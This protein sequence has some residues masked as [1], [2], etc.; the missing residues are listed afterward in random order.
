MHRTARLVVVG[1]AMVM[2]IVTAGEI[3]PMNIGLELEMNSEFNTILPRA[4]ATNF[5]TFTG[6]LGGSPPEPITA[7]SNDAT[8][9]FTCSGETFTKLSDAVNRSCN[10]QK[11]TCSQAANSAGGGGGGGDKNSNGLTVGQCD[12]QLKA[13]TAAT[14]GLVGLKL[15]TVADGAENLVFC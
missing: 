15:Q 11:N 14:E 4:G 8:R 13:C 5:Q 1:L 2:G 7:T 10:N 9:L 3:A 12:E 6:T